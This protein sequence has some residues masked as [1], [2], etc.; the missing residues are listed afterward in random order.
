MVITKFLEIIDFKK[1]AKRCCYF[2]SKSFVSFNF[3]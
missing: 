2:L 1:N 3:V